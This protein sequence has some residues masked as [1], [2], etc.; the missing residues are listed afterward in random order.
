M[1]ATRMIVRRGRSWV[2]LALATCVLVASLSASSGPARF[3]RWW[4]TAK[5][6]LWHTRP[7]IVRVTDELLDDE[8]MS[9]DCTGDHCGDLRVIPDLGGTRR[10]ELAPSERYVV[11]PKQYERFVSRKSP[12]HRANRHKRYV[13]FPETPLPN[14][15]DSL[16]TGRPANA[17]SPNGDEIVRVPLYRT[18]RQV[19]TPAFTDRT[20][21]SLADKDYPSRRNASAYY[22]ERRAVMARFYA[23]QREIRERY[24]VNRTNSSLEDDKP[25]NEVASNVTLFRLYPPRNSSLTDVD[26]ATFRHPSITIDPVYSNNPPAKP[27]ERP[28]VPEADGRLEPRAWNNSSVERQAVRY[29][30]TTPAPCA[31]ASLSGTVAPKKRSKNPSDLDNDDDHRMTNETDGTDHKI[32]G[33]CKGKVVYQHNLLLA[34]RGASS[35]LEAMFEVIIEAPICIT[36][37]EVL[38]YN[39]TRANVTFES[40]GRG[41]DYVKLKLQGYENEGFSYIIKVWGIK[42]FGP[43][44]TIYTID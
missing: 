32:W 25:R 2:V 4:P 24:G 9:P 28:V 5:M 3:R 43:N 13:A 33:E 21:R 40:G 26:G 38:R 39:Q 35:K 11:Y 8:L 22:A 18:R 31:N 6:P 20:R 16:A 30:Y 12:G 7:T 36:C 27:N 41:H 10:N 44:C 37:V 29:Y 15:T 19:E 17:T 42:K 34:L 14:A 1:V 23:R